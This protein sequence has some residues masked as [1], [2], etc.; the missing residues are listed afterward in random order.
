MKSSKLSKFYLNLLGRFGYLKLSEGF[1]GEANVPDHPYCLPSSPRSESVLNLFSSVHFAKIE[2]VPSV[3]N[4][5]T[6]LP[7]THP[8]PLLSFSA[9]KISDLFSSIQA[10]QA[11]SCRFALF[12]VG[13]VADL[14][15]VVVTFR[16][17]DF[18]ENCFHGIGIWERRWKFLVVVEAGRGGDEDEILKLILEREEKEVLTEKKRFPLVLL[19]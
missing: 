8:S 7:T 13:F 18:I 17:L 5:I 12:L 9:F 19:M 6:F 1:E 10:F 2:Y 14:V 11:Y 16:I 15:V 3:S 4:A